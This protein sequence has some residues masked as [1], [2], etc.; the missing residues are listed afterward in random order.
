MT[1]PYKGNASKNAPHLTVRGAGYVMPWDPQASFEN[2]FLMDWTRDL[3]SDKGLE[4]PEYFVY[5]GIFNPWCSAQRI[6][7]N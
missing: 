6:R 4:I 3:V 1:L 5:C 7:I 2:S